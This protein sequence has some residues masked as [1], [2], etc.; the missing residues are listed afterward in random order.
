VLTLHQQPLRDRGTDIHLL[1][2]YFT[3]K[4]C[5]Q[6]GLPKKTFSAAAK[7]NLLMHNWPGNIR[8]LENAVQKA[9]LM[10]DQQVIN[11]EDLNSDS[12]TTYQKV[13][14]DSEPVTLHQARDRAEKA[15]IINALVKTKGNVSLSSKIL[16]IDR[17]WL[18]KKMDEFGIHADRYR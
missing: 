2:E 7:K 9:I 1:L 5:Q 15:A 14:G 3:N 10:S 18:I 16:E 11:P 8:E 12:V 13:S 4:Y 17:K 6:F